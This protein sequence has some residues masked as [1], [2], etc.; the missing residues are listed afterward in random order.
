MS[1][2]VAGGGVGRIISKSFVVKMVRA[3]MTMQMDEPS[4]MPALRRPRKRRKEAMADD[5]RRRERMP[6]VIRQRGGD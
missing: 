6:S 4:Q 5:R 1:P 3:T 2:A